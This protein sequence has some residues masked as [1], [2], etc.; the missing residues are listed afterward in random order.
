MDGF[1]LNPGGLYP[2][3]PNP[4][5]LAGGYRF[6]NV[7]D[8]RNQ[9]RA[10]IAIAP[11]RP[12]GP[13]DIAGATAN[14]G[15]VSPQPQPIQVPGSTDNGVSSRPSGGLYPD[16]QQSASGGFMRRPL[17]DLGPTDP[18]GADIPQPGLVAHSH[19]QPSS[20][21]SS[22]RGDL[23]TTSSP[24]GI[25]SQQ[26]SPFYPAPSVG[27][28][29][30][31][32]FGTRKVL[33]Y[34][35][36]APGSN[37]LPRRIDSISAAEYDALPPEEK[38]RYRSAG[39]YN[40][41]IIRRAEERNPMARRYLEAQEKLGF[42]PTWDTLPNEKKHHGWHKFLDAAAAVATGVGTLNPMAGLGMYN[43]LSRAPLRE[44]QA[45]WESKAK[46]V[47]TGFDREMALAKQET[48]EDVAQAREAMYEGRLSDSER[49]AK[50]YGQKIVRYYQDPQGNWKGEQADG[51]IVD[52][53]PPPAQKQGAGDK[54]D[55][56]YHAREHQADLMG[57]PQGSEDRKY[58]LANGKLKEPGTTI[59]VPS[60]ASEAYRDWRAAF[61]RDNGRD[62][63]AQEI[64]DYRRG[65]ANKPPHSKDRQ[66]FELHWQTR[67]QQGEK[68]KD[69]KRRQAMQQ[70]GATTPQ[71][72]SEM[73]TADHKAMEAELNQI[74]AEWNVQKQQ[75]QNEKD[76]EADQ[77][78]I[79][80]QPERQIKT[81]SGKTVTLGARVKIAGK[82]GTITA[83]RNGKPVF[84]P[85]PGQ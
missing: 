52:A 36:G 47:G 49:R 67:F 56:E 12:Q 80:G 33:D 76:T 13:V 7:N 53:V 31:Q 3:A 8:P 66:T 50:E 9:Q 81:K 78:G 22:A 65:G 1:S 24:T 63:N 11:R 71:G 83:V 58:F 72:L 60:E 26:S 21:D 61:H 79:Y 69:A 19:A 10:P 18:K 70:Y 85:D 37:E 44:A 29:Q 84:T 55:E 73:K 34:D 40:A 62:P 46:Q 68:V 6:D 20:D 43:T 32:R 54:L 51:E 38:A 74:E 75:L 59:R 82:A 23:P 48:G 14:T 27:P 39:D 41:E 25:S 42:E 64:N 30:S 45:D 15:A 17:G 35:T 2:K 4:S 5:A 16:T 28:Q 57:L 77:Y